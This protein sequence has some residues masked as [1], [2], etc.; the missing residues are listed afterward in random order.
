ME[1]GSPEK[2][3][4]DALADALA[5]EDDQIEWT[6][7]K[8]FGDTMFGTDELKS[9][10]GDPNRHKESLMEQFPD[11]K[12]SIEKFFAMSRKASK[13]WFRA[14]AFK[15]MPR[16]VSSCLIN[17]GLDRL[18]NKD[19]RKYAQMTVGGVLRSLTNDNDLQTILGGACVAYGMTPDEA[20]FIMHS[21][22]FA[23][24]KFTL[25][26]P[27]GGPGMIPEKISRA[28]TAGGG[29]VRVNAKVE[30][31]LVE[32]GHAVGVE[33]ADGKKIRAK[34]QVISDA[35]FVKTFRQFVSAKDQPSRRMRAA[36]EGQLENG[37]TG[38]VLY[39][40]LQGTFDDD[41]NLPC[42]LTIVNP[43]MAFP[44]TLDGLAEMRAEDLSLYITCPSAKDGRWKKD[45]P[46]KTTL[47][48]LLMDV[49]WKAFEDLI[50][51]NGE[52]KEG[53]KE[54]YDQFKHDFGQK[55]WARS[56]QALISA[57]ADK[58][59]PNLLD[60][61]DFAEIGTP[62]TFHRYLGSDRG[63]WYGLEHSRARFSPRNYYLRLR[64]ECDIDGLYLTGED[65]AT[66]GVEGAMFGGYLCAAKILGVRN[67][68]DLADKVAANKAKD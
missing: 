57:G 30:K 16:W 2:K 54:A 10:K 39:V 33:L 46:G 18:L 27:A 41:F 44:E 20:P 62:L 15:S 8:D 47:E 28:I 1:D 12:E 52:L 60:E 51:E 21:V 14:F 48:I 43:D 36:T 6:P 19:Y 38:I 13:C 59:L 53:N 65:V 5:L 63:A 11:E 66:D 9:Y 42:H 55:I 35:G 25:F 31:I 17:T 4:M 23:Q 68:L 56:R 67:P 37:M 24:D 32:N 29:E 7:M 61:A 49:P 64:P 34:D 22:F 45:Y 50:D 58:A 40:G 3:M 26:Y